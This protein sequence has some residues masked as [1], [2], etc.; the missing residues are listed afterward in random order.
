MLFATDGECLQRAQSAGLRCLYVPF[1]EPSIRH[2]WAY[3]Q[4]RAK[5]R[6]ALRAD[7]PALIH[8]NDLPT[9]RAVSD[10]ARGLGIPMICH[11]RGVFDGP[12][13]DWF[14]KFPAARHLFVS[15]ALCEELC[16]HS[17]RLR[18]CPKAVVYDGVPI[19][20]ARS[21]SSRATARAR[22][23]VATDD[24]VVTFTGRL[25]PVKG[26]D[27]LLQA[28]AKVRDG[29]VQ[30]AELVLVGGDAGSPGNAQ[31]LADLNLELNARARFVGHQAD[32]SS[33]L[34]AADV[35]VVPS[36]LEPLGNAPLEASAEGLPVVAS[37]VGGLP[38]IVADGVTGLLVP[39]GDPTA[40]AAALIRLLDDPGLRRRFGDQA[41]IRCEQ[42][43]S[44]DAHV[45]AVLD[46]YQ[47]VL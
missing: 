16:A 43:F 7:G 20:P 14:L 37:R 15:H 39:P 44:M 36:L 5:L 6:N 2:Y 34:H 38:E 10:A 4:A 28:W 47:E 40:L 31:K 9:H 23:G 24:V 11:H 42:R 18:S 13:I 41:R 30:A 33:W 29:T 17:S 19:P 46:Q 26:V 27:V 35:A 3:R 25:V 1:V 32:V 22:I 8:S 45:D 21:A 12:A